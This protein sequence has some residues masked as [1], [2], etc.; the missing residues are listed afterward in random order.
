MY[1]DENKQ[2]NK[3]THNYML[4]DVIFVKQSLSVHI[5]EQLIA[6]ISCEFF[7]TFNFVYILSAKR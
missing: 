3:Q 1:K 2:T 7:S 4:F 5:F 6:N